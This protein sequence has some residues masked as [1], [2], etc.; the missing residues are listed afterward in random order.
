[1]KNGEGSKG[2][3]GQSRLKRDPKGAL[4]KRKILEGYLYFFRLLFIL[5]KDS[6]GV[7]SEDSRVIIA[8]VSSTVYTIQLAFVITFHFVD[9]TSTSNTVVL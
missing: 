2:Y 1:M 9:Y 4:A 7:L 5:Q 6:R 3:N 8:K